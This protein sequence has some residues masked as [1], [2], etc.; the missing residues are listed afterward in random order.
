MKL[1]I[2]STSPNC[3]STRRLREAALD[4]GHTCKVLNTLKFSIDVAAG[5]PALYYRQNSLSDYDAV[6]PRIGASITYF[7]T[8]VLRQFEQMDIFCAN[9]AAGVTN[10]RDKLRCLQILSR[11]QLGIPETTF[12]RDKKDVLPAIERVGGAPVIIKLFEG[13]HPRPWSLGKFGARGSLP[14]PTL[15]H[16]LSL[17]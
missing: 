2:L 6:L 12:V 15:S 3:Y 13:T 5:N 9:T 7:G 17:R 11:H 10:S 4:R 14:S 8:A 1:G 16:A